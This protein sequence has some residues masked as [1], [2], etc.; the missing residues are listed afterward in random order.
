MCGI[1]GIISSE[2]TVQPILSA[3]DRMS[4]R[5]YDSA[6]LAVCGE[7]GIAI[8][9]AS[10]KIANLVREVQDNPASGACGIGHTRWATHGAPSVRNAHPHRAGGV[11]VVHNGIIENHED[12]RQRLSDENIHPTSDTDSE[13]VAILI[14]REIKKG[15]SPVDAV[16]RTMPQL[17][18]AYAL[19]ILFDGF[20]DLIVVA[21][22][23]S[24]LA[25]GVK[26]KISVTGSDAVSMASL[27]DQAC[28]LE[29]GD[30]A[31][32]EPGRTRIFDR[33]GATVDRP[34][35]DV[36][37]A[38]KAGDKEGFDHFMA[39][40]MHEQ[41]R[42][43][44]RT[45][46][47]H[48]DA[49]TLRPRGLLSSIDMSG[50][51]RLHMVAC[52]TSYY[53][54]KTARVWIEHLTGWPVDLDIASEAVHRSRHISSCDLGIFISQSGETADTLAALSAFRNAGGKTLAFVNVPQSTIARAADMVLPLEAGPEIGV[55]STKA[56]TCQL[57]ALGCFAIAAGMAAGAADGDLDKVARDLLDTPRIIR[58]TLAQEKTYKDIAPA[59]MSARSAFFLG[60][61][62]LYPIALEGA[63]KLKEISY[64]HAEGYAAGEL[65]HGPIALIDETVPSV[66]IAHSSD[67]LAAKTLSSAQEIAA[68]GGALFIMS[69]HAD[70]AAE[71][72]VLPL[73]ACR[74][75]QAPFAAAVGGQ[76]LAYHVARGLGR[77][78]DQPRNLAKAVCV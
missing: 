46:A 64:I 21:R 58:D 28:Y 2:D 11:V 73:P 65:K 9:R 24:P 62:S 19:A 39:K 70:I 26:D 37:Y 47:T 42:A 31:T 60:R 29:N 61:G 43:T 51:T 71:H 20:P 75:L 32:I 18:G 67:P 69:D 14:D 76:M 44:A 68:R 6:G 22:Q 55:A 5:G 4:Y 63:L 59:F 12:I 52:G 38:G 25:I 49:A 40:E 41:P 53:A 48:L 8:R 1:F 78:V 45:L 72:A 50:I 27:V 10:G 7:A 34:F 33:S 66:V 74:E 30:I 56:F 36:S 13:L 57:A 3:L 23:G 77:D 17:E 15:K 54:A 35:K 16:S